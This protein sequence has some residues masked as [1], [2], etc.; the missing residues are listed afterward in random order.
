[1]T[2]A[3]KKTHWKKLVNPLYIGAYS[4]NPNEDL[5]VKITHVG[6]EIVTT[7]GGKKEEC[8]VAQ[9]ENNK[10]MILNATNS[11]TIAKLYGSYIEDWVGKYIQLYESK[12]M[13][14]G[15][16]VECLRIRPVSPSLDVKPRPQITA[17]R[18]AA[19]L[20]SISA[21]EYT[22]D[23]LEQNFDLSPEQMDAVDLAKD[24]IR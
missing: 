11:K 14:A 8:T 7:T 22:F 4:L 1:M 20:K 18:F 10:P 24:A 15:E 13:L 17:E 12:A 5:I 2:N 6:R 9:L 23:K 21:G 19:A 3:E 16:N